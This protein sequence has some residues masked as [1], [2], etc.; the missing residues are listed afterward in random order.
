MQTLSTDFY[1]SPPGPTKTE[2]QKRHTPPP[3]VGEEDMLLSVIPEQLE[4]VNVDGRT[5][6]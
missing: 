3:S 5:H 4:Q 1:W 6:R 2:L